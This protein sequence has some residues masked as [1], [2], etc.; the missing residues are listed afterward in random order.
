MA[1]GHDFGRKQELVMLTKK[2]ISQRVPYRSA[3][4]QSTVKY[5][6]LTRGSKWSFFEGINA[7]ADSLESFNGE[8]WGSE[9]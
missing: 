6:G 2:R 3:S 7:A 5:L 9:V 1:T 8:H 4:R